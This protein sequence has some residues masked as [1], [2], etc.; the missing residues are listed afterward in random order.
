M[1]ASRVSRT[2]DTPSMRLFYE[3]RL[4]QKTGGVISPG[5][6]QMHG[7]ILLWDSSRA[8][9][10][11]VDHK[12]IKNVSDFVAHLRAHIALHHVN[13]DCIHSKVPL[14]SLKKRRLEGVLPLKLHK[15][16]ELF[17]A[18]PNKLVLSTMVFTAHANHLHLLTKVSER[19]DLK[20]P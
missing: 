7:V 15:N 16:C 12:P 14:S 9:G 1:E 20:Q 17:V 5:L 13:L 4:D 8:P 3:K 10:T 11:G 18:N 6:R 2:G 19:K